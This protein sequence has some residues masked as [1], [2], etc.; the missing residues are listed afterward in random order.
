MANSV[1]LVYQS[2]IIYT[3]LMKCLYGKHYI[4]RYR[5][6]A[7]KIPRGASVTD[8]C[9]GDSVLYTRYLKGKNKYTGIDINPLTSF[10]SQWAKIIKVDIVKEAI[11]KA[12]YVVMQGSLYQFI[13]NHKEIINKMLDSARYKVII[14]EPVINLVNSKNKIIST[15]AK[16]S[17][18]PSTGNKKF[19]F[20]K[21]SLNND[22]QRYFKQYIENIY[23]IAG[24][25]DM[26]VVLNTK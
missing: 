20:T 26:V 23:F 1:S 13:P 2:K 24:G 5:E 9:S 22:L 16:Y 19:R 7:E 8:V 17:A 21:E 4:Y 14:S 12:D 11:P 15:I 3:L 10:N 25:R 18:N 6:I